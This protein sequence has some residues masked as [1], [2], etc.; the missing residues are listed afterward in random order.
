MSTNDNSVSKIISEINYKLGKKLGEGMFS[1][2]KV[3]VH[4]LTNEQVAI[5]IL[6]KAK[7]NS[8][9]DKE[10]MNREIAIMKRISHYNIAKLYQVVET[11]FITYLIQENVPGKDLLEH[12]TKKGKL[13]EVEACKFFHQMISAL[14]YIH[15]CGIAHRDFKPENIIVTNNN[16]ILKIIDFGLGNMYKSGQLLK[17]GCGSPCYVP[18]EMIKEEM[19]DG[20]LSDIWS[21]GIILYYMLC[22][23]LPF[24]DDDNQILYE[25]I[26]SG[27]FTTP[28]NLSEDAKD[29]LSKILEIDPKKRLNFE[30]I[31]A[32]PWFSLIKKNSLMHKGINIDVDIIPIDEDIIQKMEK[33]GFDKVETRYNILKNYHNKLTTVYDLLLKR[34]MD[35]GIKSVSDMNSDLYDAYMENK[36]NKIESYGSIEKVLKNRI[37][38]DEKEVDN[39]PNYPENKYEEN[40]ENTVI[41]ESGSVLER[42]IKSGRFTYDEESMSLNKVNQLRN[43]KKDIDFDDD[44]RFKTI[45]AIRTTETPLSKG[46]K[47]FK[48][49][50]EHKEKKNKVHFEK[51]EKNEEKDEKTKHSPKKKSNLKPG[52]KV[53]KVKVNEEDEDWFKE[54]S[55]QIDQENKKITEHKK[56]AKTPRVKKN[57]A[58]IEVPSLT[59]PQNN[60]DLYSDDE[61]FAKFSL[62]NRES[63]SK[64]ENEKVKENRKTMTKPGLNKASKNYKSTR[65]IRDKK[66]TTA[67][68]KQKEY[69]STRNMIK[70][71][72]K[73][74]SKNPSNKEGKK[75]ENSLEKTAKKPNKFKKITGDVEDVNALRRNNSCEKRTRKIDI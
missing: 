62:S 32:H 36:K 30:G 60:N 23:N 3:G 15:Q 67:M 4:S 29:I 2:V 24:F 37:G 68:A 45:S 49:N 35:I 55:D 34:K 20:A 72:K 16:Q 58:K 63:H 10:R 26:L 1:T 74:N 48:K 28:D 42:L 12:I 50:E 13:T 59:I 52:K 19:Y 21:S 41:G 75:K 46:I 40:N 65:A 54:I 14:D 69:Y 73:K 6:E 43:K 7:I 33:M 39:V 70:V 53:E 17:T 18:P 61:E 44:S 25:K 22:G 57:K 31:K 8:R 66:G 27:K 9:E 47:K 38:N 71:P 5:K 64:L 11:K 51:E 56:E